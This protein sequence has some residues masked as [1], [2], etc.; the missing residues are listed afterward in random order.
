[1]EQTFDLPKICIDLAEPEQKP[2]TINVTDEIAKMEKETNRLLKSEVGRRYRGQDISKEFGQKL[3]EIRREIANEYGLPRYSTKEMKTFKEMKKYHDSV[4]DF[5][6]KSLT[7]SDPY[8]TVSK[9]SSNDS[10]NDLFDWNTEDQ[11]SEIL[12]GNLELA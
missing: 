2:L 3:A 9:M 7:N 6:S 10:I 4:K 12:Y 5:V 11:I 8:Q 1:M